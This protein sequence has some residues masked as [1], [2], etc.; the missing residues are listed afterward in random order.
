MFGILIQV[1]SGES[2]D[3]AIGERP[4]SVLDVASLLKQ[5]LRLLSL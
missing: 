5:F 2:L 4:P 1:E 3:C